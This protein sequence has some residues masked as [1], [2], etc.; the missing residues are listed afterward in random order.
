MELTSCCEMM[1]SSSGA[2]FLQPLFLL[3][4]DFLFQPWMH[5]ISSSDQD[6]ILNSW[7]CLFYSTSNGPRLHSIFL[8]SQK[9]HPNQINP[10]HCFQI[11]LKFKNKNHQCSVSEEWR[12][13]CIHPGFK[14]LGSHLKCTSGSIKF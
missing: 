13:L 12:L 6:R 8:R 3:F 5:L 14:A 4:L 2:S 1:N 11:I 9:K 10:P 7:V